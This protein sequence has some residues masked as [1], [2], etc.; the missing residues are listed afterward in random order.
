MKK[1]TLLLLALP[2]FV[3]A[4]AQT[5][6]KVQ[7]ESLLA[8]ANIK[9]DG[10]ITEWGN[11]LLAYNPTT[12]VSYTMANDAENLYIV[13]S[14]AGQ[15]MANRV[16]AGGL[17]FA[18]GRS[19]K[20]DEKDRLVFT[21]PTYDTPTHKERYRINPMP[22]AY[23]AEYAQEQ[24]VRN[25]GILKDNVKYIRT[26]GVKGV[27]TLLSIYNA[28]NIKAAAGFSLDENLNLNIEM[29]IPLKLLAGYNTGD[30]LFYSLRVNG[31][32]AH[33]T[34]TVNV[35][36]ADGHQ[37]TQE[38]IDKGV[39]QANEREALLSAPTEFSAE[40]ALSK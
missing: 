7:K 34:T 18:V 31:G 1:I 2:G 29:S 12:E 39:A 21:F 11:R 6:P 26:A 23:G 19:N 22:K 10:N 15:D 28:F 32:N 30:K 36:F 38:D 8:P 3:S 33:L 40:Y 13:A 25:N 37:A 14:V 9:I 24:L 20:K 27:D 17:S 4:Y 5:L 16:Y 35:Y